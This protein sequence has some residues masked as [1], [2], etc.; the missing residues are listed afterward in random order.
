MKI[1]RKLNLVLRLG[2]DGPEEIHIHHSPIMQAVFE[3]HYMFIAKSMNR[4]Y[5]EGLHPLIAMHVAYFTMRDLAKSE[6]RYKSVPDTLFAEIQRMTNALVLKDR[7]WEVVPFQ[8]AID[9][10]L[11]SDADVLE[12]MNS[13]C[14]FTSDRKSVV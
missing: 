7:R 6:P 13:L 2:D 11:I 10:K 3:R 9:A 12:V 14:F 1:D 4:M 8:E 5:S